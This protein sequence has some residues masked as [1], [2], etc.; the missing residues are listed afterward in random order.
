MRSYTSKVKNLD[1]MS[2][3][4]DVAMEI[5]LELLKEDFNGMHSANMPDNILYNKDLS[6]RFESSRIGPMRRLMTIG[7]EICGTRPLNLL[8][9]PGKHDDVATL[10][11]KTRFA[12]HRARQWRQAAVKRIK[13]HS[14]TISDI[15]GGDYVSTGTVSGNLVELTIRKNKLA[16]IVIIDNRTD[17]CAVTPSLAKDFIDFEDM[18]FV[19]NTLSEVA[20]KMELNK[21]LEAL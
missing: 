17:K 18:A 2:V 6:I 21:K 1:S 4:E 5:T 7:A 20:R 14:K 13:R 9:K 15:L 12:L 11:Q 8:I 3:D 16:M 10:M 19:W